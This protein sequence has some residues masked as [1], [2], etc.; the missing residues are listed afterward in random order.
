MDLE[1]ARALLAQAQQHRQPAYEPS[2]F[3]LG[4][5]GYYER[6]PYH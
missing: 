3:A 1:Q 2:I 6:K 5:R 4:G